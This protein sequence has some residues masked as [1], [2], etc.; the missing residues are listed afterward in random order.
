MGRLQI[1]AFQK[2]SAH[3][4]NAESI[5]KYHV[6]CMQFIELSVSTLGQKCLIL[7]KEKEAMA[8]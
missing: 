4:V 6:E 2:S 3:L 8:W 7:G 1:A 5:L